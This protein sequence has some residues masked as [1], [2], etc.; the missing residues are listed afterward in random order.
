MKFSDN[1]AKTIQ[2]VLLWTGFAL[3]QT[4]SFNS[5]FL[6]PFYI[7]LVDAIF[8]SL[9]YALL[10]ILLWNTLRF[11]NFSVLPTL[12]RIINYAALGLLTLSIATGAGYGFEYI[13]GVS[14][15]FL[16]YLPARTFIH[17]LVFILIIQSFIINN[18]SKHSENIPESETDND[19]TDEETTISQTTEIVERI[20]VKSGQKIDMIPVSEVLCI[21]ADG[22]YV[23]IHT[24]KGKYMKEQTMKSFERMLPPGLFVRV[25]RSCIVNIESISRIEL[26]EKQGRL[27][28]LKNNFKI[29][30]SQTGYAI[31]KEKLNL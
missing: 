11:G 1:K 25:H 27:L 30:V 12:Q 26:Y 15:D 6:L 10:G 8:H 18:H 5:I 13:L 17:L 9:L 20:A 29:K 3:L 4:L 22:D 31:L 24:M 21:Q 16:P 2:Y 14:A 28:T 7:I 19:D 23:H